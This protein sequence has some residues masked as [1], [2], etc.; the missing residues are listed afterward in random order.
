MNV[1]INPPSIDL[2]KDL[3]DKEFELR[4]K[5]DAVG[6]HY[7][8]LKKTQDNFQKVII[9]LSLFT[10][11]L[12]TVKTQLNLTQSNNSVVSNS[13][14][15]CPIFLSTIVGIISS[16]LKFRDF[17]QKLE[18]DSKAIEKASYAITRIRELRSSLN[19]EERVVIQNSYLDTALSTHREALELIETTLN[20]KDRQNLFQQAQ[21]NLLKIGEDAEEFKHKLKN[22]KPYVPKVMITA[23]PMKPLEFSVDTEEPPV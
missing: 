10:A 20:P 15:V 4:S 21:H 2:H 1:Q 3:G 11:L 18:N 12:E 6:I 14:A 22:L 13:S 5:R 9:V 23:K 17:P 16:L 19:F 7:G 8:A